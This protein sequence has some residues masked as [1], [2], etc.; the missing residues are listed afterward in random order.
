M[1][2]MRWPW[3]PAARKF[4]VRLVV[5]RA[6]GLP[7]APATDADAEARMAVELKWKGPKARW[8][9]LR[10]CRNRTRL[11]A[12]APAVDAEFSAAAVAW[13]EEFEDVVTLTAVSHR[14]PA[15]AFHPWD[16][17]FSVLNV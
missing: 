2:A 8:K 12:P 5:R 1:L 7:L 6:E 10:V 16:L 4:S 14:K 15:A 17:F 11:E 13:E 3:P 9:G